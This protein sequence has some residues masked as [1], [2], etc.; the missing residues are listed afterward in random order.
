MLI[1]SMKF[2]S[3]KSFYHE[4]QRH[5]SIRPSLFA[6][7]KSSVRLEKNAVEPCL[8]D[9]LLHQSRHSNSHSLWKRKYLLKKKTFHKINFYYIACRLI[10]YAF[11]HF[12]FLSRIRLIWWIFFKVNGN[13]TVI[14]CDWFRWRKKSLS[15]VKFQC[16]KFSPF[17][18]QEILS[19]THL[20]EGLKC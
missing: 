4:Q 14:W 20:I 7:P 5:M 11:M 19:R 10:F 17:A 18:Y 2:Y 8:N 16:E 15:V 3:F 1:C 9:N 12:V 13:R 6:G